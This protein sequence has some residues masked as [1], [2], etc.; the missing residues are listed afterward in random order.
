MHGRQW[1]PTAPQVKY[2]RGSFSFL[3]AFGRQ[4]EL[5]L[6]LELDGSAPDFVSDALGVLQNALEGITGSPVGDEGAGGS[7]DDVSGAD[8]DSPSG[9][10]VPLANRGARPADSGRAVDGAT[11]GLSRDTVCRPQ[12][13]PG[14]KAR[15]A[16]VRD[17][18]RGT[19]K[20][21]GGKTRAKKR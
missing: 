9:L 17:V 11:R 2:D 20:R 8:S 12:G 14:Q 13:D 21:K 15:G 1:S 18:P 10:R 16:I 7:D 19:R 4:L 5:A 6:E 3:I